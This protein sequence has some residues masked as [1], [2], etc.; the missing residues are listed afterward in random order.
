MNDVRVFDNA[1]LAGGIGLLFAAAVSP[2]QA[3][4]FGAIVALTAIGVQ[5]HRNAA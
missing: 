4:G 3:L 2:T 5:L 1:A